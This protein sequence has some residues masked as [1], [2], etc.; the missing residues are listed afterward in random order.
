MSKCNCIKEVEQKT[1]AHLKERYPDKTYNEELNGFEGTGLLNQALSMGENG[2]YKLYHQFAIE[3]TFT[4]VNGTQSKPKK[5]TVNIY[6]TFCPFCGIRL[7][8]EN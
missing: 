4:K 1:I 6:Q 3:V 2:G 5:E 7:I 8:E